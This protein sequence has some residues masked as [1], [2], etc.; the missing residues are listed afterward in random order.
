MEFN[1]ALFNLLLEGLRDTLIMVL[2]STLMGYLLG[3]PLGV[4]LTVT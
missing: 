4:L 1:S 3:L 2:A